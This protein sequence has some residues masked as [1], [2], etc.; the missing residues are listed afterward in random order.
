MTVGFNEEQFAILEAFFGSKREELTQVL[1]DR[2][3]DVPQ[4]RDLEWRLEA[5]VFANSINFW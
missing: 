3:I 5:Q 4:F 2:T 1:T